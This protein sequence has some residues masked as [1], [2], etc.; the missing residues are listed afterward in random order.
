M[1][2][3]KDRLLLLPGLVL[4]FG[5]ALSAYA[6]RVPEEK[7]LGDWTIYEFR[8]FDLDPLPPPKGVA[9]AAKT[10]ALNGRDASLALFCST[11]SVSYLIYGDD[12]FS[13]AMQAAAAGSNADIYNQ[14]LYTKTNKQ[15]SFQKTLSSAGYSGHEFSTITE[16]LLSAGSLMVC[17]MQDDKHPACLTFSLRGIT[18]AL[19][20]I[21]PKR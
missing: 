17:P 9:D 6:Q 18:A 1:I 14:L 20:A 16:T 11:Y 2:A 10:P 21:C 7:K 8:D 13:D 15:E 3:R 12:Q 19:K 4:I 5:P